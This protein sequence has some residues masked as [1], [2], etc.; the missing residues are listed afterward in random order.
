MNPNG[1]Y[2]VHFADPDMYADPPC[3]NK[4]RINV[5]RRCSYFQ[6]QDILQVILPRKSA[7][8]AAAGR[9]DDSAIP[10]E[11]ILNCP[12]CLSPPVAPRMTKC[13]H[14]SPPRPTHYTDSEHYVLIDLLFPLHPTLSYDLR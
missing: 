5:C 1:D 2:T 4:I 14:V 6:W 8:A 10:E 12:I 9:Q 3:S 11:G 7:L 13:G